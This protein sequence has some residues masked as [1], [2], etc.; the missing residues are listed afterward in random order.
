MAEVLFTED[1]WRA[2]AR[3]E[4]DDEHRLRI[5][6]PH[7]WN[8]VRRLNGA[9]WD[10]GEFYVAWPD[11]TFER[12]PKFFVYERMS[13]LSF[14]YSE[15]SKADAINDAREAIAL[16]GDYLPHLIAIWTERYEPKRVEQEAQA[17]E[18]AAYIAK[19]NRPRKVTQRCR[20]I[21][22]K[23]KGVCHYCKTEL[24]LE[25]KWHIDHMTP[26]ARG[27]SDDYANLVASCA[28]C[29]HRK[30]TRT[31]AEFFAY[32]AVCDAAEAERRAT[33]LAEEEAA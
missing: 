27:G 22:A 19:R 17:A 10:A 12:D 14:G 15:E 18:H 25:G 6:P 20:D 1:Q 7:M 30:H 23:S 33:E 21:F 5:H 2:I 3:V 9:T 24:T 32:M 31:E 8:E 16:I 28:P 29:N 4:A 26:R 13:G 11:D